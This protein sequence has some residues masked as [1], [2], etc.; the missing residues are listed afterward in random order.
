[1]HERLVLDGMR[2]SVTLALD[3]NLDRLFVIAQENEP[4][5]SLGDIASVLPAVD[6]S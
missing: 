2:R 3:K 5:S 6:M 4:T 1:M